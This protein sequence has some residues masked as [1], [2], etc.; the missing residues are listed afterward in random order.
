MK[1]PRASFSPLFDLLIIYERQ[2]DRL[3]RPFL[4]AS[5]LL[6]SGKGPVPRIQTSRVP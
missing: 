2:P 4:I 3:D 1:A 6:R 5:F